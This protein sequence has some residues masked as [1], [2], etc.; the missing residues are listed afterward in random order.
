MAIREIVKK[1]ARALTDVISDSSTAGFIRG[2]AGVLSELPS[3]ALPAAGLAAPPVFVTPPLT[4]FPEGAGPFVRFPVVEAAAKRVAE[5]KIVS[6]GVFAGLDSE[7]KEQAFTITT[8]M[9]D[10]SVAKIRDLLHENIARGADRKAF[11][12][13]VDDL[14]GEGMPLSRAHVEQIFRN[15]VNVAY[16]DGQHR[17]LKAPLVVGAFPYREYFATSDQRVRKEHFALESLG[18][19]GTAVYNRLDPV[20][21][22]FRPPWSWNCRCVSTPLTVEMAAE[23]GVKEAQQWLDRAERYA[24]QRDLD[25]D[26][27]LD[28]TKPNQFQFVKMP[29][30]ADDP[31]VLDPSW[32]RDGAT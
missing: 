17:A 11:I 5:A 3:S 28:Q 20:W 23:T 4:G 7:A 9:A 30:F 2:A 24:E 29:K 6:P 27:V 8:D 31:K 22:L 12:R 13:D 32:R 16:S 10:E 14:F 21:H 25:P 26:L 1:T 15:N 18:L 19:D